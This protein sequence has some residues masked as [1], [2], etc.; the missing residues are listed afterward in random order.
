MVFFS[1]IVDLPFSVH[2]F[3][4][5][6]VNLEYLLAI[7]HRVVESHQLDENRRE[8]SEHLGILRISLQ[9]FFV[10]FKGLR[11]LLTLV[12][13]VSLLSMF[14]GKFWVDVSQFD[15]FLFVPLDLS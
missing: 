7:F 4:V 11:V 13:L 9:S 2:S 8:I 10:L 1:E 14:L 5:L 3:D 15:C 6:R 12:E